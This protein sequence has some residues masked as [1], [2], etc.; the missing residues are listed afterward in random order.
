MM[1]AAVHV[2]P[3]ISVPVAIAAAVTL[4]WYWWRLG[5]PT[6]PAPRRRLRRVSLVLMIIA[7]PTLVRGLS[8]V[9]PAIHKKA[10]V[11]SWTFV[12]V[13][14]GLIFVTALLDAFVSMH[15]HRRAYE[16][17][18]HDAASTLA[19]ALREQDGA[20]RAGDKPG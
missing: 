7:L 2:H 4:M 3:V 8:F 16:R 9:D 17:E 19:Q 13:M 15:L 1:F 5:R 6:V 14:V 12:L 11:L 10:Y 20:A 18:L